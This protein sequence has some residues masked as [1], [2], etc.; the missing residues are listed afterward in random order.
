MT[1]IIVSV[2][3]KK[4]GCFYDEKGKEY[5]IRYPFNWHTSGGAFI[6]VDHT[7]FINIVR[8]VKLALNL[9]KYDYVVS[10]REL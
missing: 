1:I 6:E 10:V 4:N 5:P 7:T 2:S 9:D 3:D 8:P